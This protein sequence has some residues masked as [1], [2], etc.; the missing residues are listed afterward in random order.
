VEASYT[1]DERNKIWLKERWSEKCTE[2]LKI[3]NN[4]SAKNLFKL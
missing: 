4:D 3:E 1:G 2:D